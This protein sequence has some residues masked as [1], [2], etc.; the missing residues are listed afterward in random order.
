MKALIFLFNITFVMIGIFTPI[1][2]VSNNNVEMDIDIEISKLNKI[3]DIYDE[4]NNSMN[5]YLSV[6]QSSKKRI[7]EIK[8]DY[9][10]MALS[11]FDIV[12]T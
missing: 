9:I 7:N 8:S 1:S 12:F 3:S 4:L 10:N 2:V 6:V 11:N 5:E